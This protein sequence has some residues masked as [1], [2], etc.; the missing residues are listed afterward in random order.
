MTGVKIIRVAQHGGPEVLEPA[1]LRERIIAT[2]HRL[3]RLYSAA[4]VTESLASGRA[5]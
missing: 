1:E 2:V 4:T 3:S 5:R